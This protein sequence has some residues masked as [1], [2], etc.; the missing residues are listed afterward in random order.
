MNTKQII[1]SIIVSVIV[2]ILGFSFF[3]GRIERV[4][5]SPVGSVTSDKITSDKWCVGGICSFS[6]TY[7]TGPTNASTTA[8]TF[9]SPN[10]ATSTPLILTWRVAS[11][12]AGVNSWYLATSTNRGSTS[13]LQ[14]IAQGSIAANV[15]NDVFEWVNNGIPPGLTRVDGVASTTN[16]K[17]FFL[18]ANESLVLISPNSANVG[19]RCGAEIRS[20]Y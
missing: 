12:S 13:T 7:Q 20:I 1:I 19:Y 14:V 3:G 6:R 9:D 16:G 5:Q 11:S 2:V 18:G 17:S 8:C 15:P 10:R 4:S